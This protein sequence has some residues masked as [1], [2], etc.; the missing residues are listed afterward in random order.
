MTWR[1][2]MYA[3]DALRLEDRIEFVMP[4]A[5][6]PEPSPADV[7]AKNEAAMKALQA[8]MGGLVGSRGKR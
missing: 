3:A 7:K 5:S 1:T 4:G 6:A 8:K 2:F